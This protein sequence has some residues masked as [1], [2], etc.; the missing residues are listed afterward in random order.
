M[1]QACAQVTPRPGFAWSPSPSGMGRQT[2]GQGDAVIPACAGA[3]GSPRQLDRV[4]EQVELGVALV[5]DQGLGHVLEAG[6][7]GR[8]GPEADRRRAAP[9]LQ[10][11]RYSAPSATGRSD[12]QARVLEPGCQAELL[13]PAARAGD[14]EGRRLAPDRPATRSP[15]TGRR[16]R[17]SS[18]ATRRRARCSAGEARP[19]RGRGR[20]RSGRGGRTAGAAEATRPAAGA[21][22]VKVPGPRMIRVPR[23]SR[24]ISWSLALR[25]IRALS[26]RRLPGGKLLAEGPVERTTRMS[27]SGGA[28]GGE[29]GGRDQ[30]ARERLY[31]DPKTK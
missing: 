29:Q 3:I 11:R 31:L 19:S 21:P 4:D 13:R 15:S 2:A 28:G 17:R 16:R 14:V 30:R 22:A 10:D 27:A 23:P 7:P 26:G 9:P 5:A 8:H 20:R 6:G 25:L 1:A 24:T 18:F 12:G